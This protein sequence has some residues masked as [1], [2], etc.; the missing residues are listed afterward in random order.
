[1]LR[2]LIY[3][4]GFCFRS[5][6]KPRKQRAERPKR[7]GLE[8]AEE[9]GLEA[10]GYLDLVEYPVRSKERRIPGA[11]GFAVEFY[12]FNFIYYFLKVYMV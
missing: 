11:C 12:L 4:V 9:G 10:F 6:T 8:Q 3:D 7:P 5:S 2:F 1:M